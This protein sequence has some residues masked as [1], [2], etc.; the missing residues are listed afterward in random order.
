MQ[1]DLVLRWIEQLGALIRRLLHG[2]AE[3]DFPAA[4]EQIREATDALLGSLSLLVPRLD[5]A[6][7]AELLADPH[8]LFGYAQLLDLEGVVAGA[9]GDEATRQEQRA[10][11]LGF[12]AEA[13]RRAG[14]PQ[15][16]WEQWIAERAT[17]P[18][19]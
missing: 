10:R 16:E 13:L 17:G 2:R 14:D 6:S 18:R 9:M 11:A 1:R 15:P 19:S 12:A 5:V 4:R 8:R 3:A 7:A